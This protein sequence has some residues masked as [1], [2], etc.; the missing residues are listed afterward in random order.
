MIIGNGHIHG[1]AWS[2]FEKLE[3]IYPGLELV[4]LKLKERIRLESK[5]LSCLVRFL[6]DNV[7]CTLSAENIMNFGISRESAEFIRDTVK[8]VN[9][10]H[11]T[12]S[13]RKYKTI[14]RFQFPRYPSLFHIIAQEY[15]D[16]LSEDENISL[17]EKLNSVLK[18]VKALLEKE[19]TDKYEDLD[20]LLEAAIPCIYYC[21]EDSS[22]WIGQEDKKYSFNAS[23]VAEVFETFSSSQKRDFSCRKF[24]RK[25][26]I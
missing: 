6:N 10:H 7:T 9:I 1:S 3:K 5:D 22:I 19:D 15:P 20:D 8:E 4:F 13:C 12:K 16:K 26:G 14:C 25:N 21:D 17:W 2:D 11:H 18:E 24:L 23:K